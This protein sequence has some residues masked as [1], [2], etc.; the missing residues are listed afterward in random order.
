MFCFDLVATCLGLDFS[1]LSVLSLGLRFTAVL[2]IWLNCL[3]G[4]RQNFGGIWRLRGFF[5]V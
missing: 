3:D 4:S 2:W 5:L 1:V